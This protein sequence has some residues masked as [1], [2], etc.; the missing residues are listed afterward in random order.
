MHIFKIIAV[1]LSLILFGAA[2]TSPSIPEAVA[3]N[4][5]SPAIMRTG[6]VTSITESDN[7]VVKVSGSNV[8][9]QASYLFPQY[10]PVLGDIVAI[11]K[12][13]AQWLVLGTMSGAINSSALNPSF[14]EGTTGSVPANWT[15]NSVSGAGGSITFQKQTGSYLG[16]PIAGNFVGAVDFTSNG[17]AAASQSNINS[18]LIDASDGEIWTG[19]LWIAGGIMS[20]G[21]LSLQTLFLEFYD[22]GGGLLSSNI[23]AQYT[24]GDITIPR[25]Y[26][27]PQA[28]SAGL[29]AP[30]GTGA[31]RLR[32]NVQ[33]V[34]PT[35]SGGTI[36]TV[37]YDY[38]ILRGPL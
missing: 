16:Q 33:F 36:S 20:S 15:I 9:V 19:G 12:Q 31:V 35:P 17:A 28:A 7:I 22:N 13:D 14:E 25:T 26:L 18:D 6:V 10:L 38:A 27:R 5:E 8:L 30:I 21:T 29:V 1:S 11:T 34:M 2:M 37:F 4:G 23:I 32:L 3:E 24:L